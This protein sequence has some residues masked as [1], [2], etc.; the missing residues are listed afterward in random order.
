M[1]L[2][3]HSHPS[4]HQIKS[5]SCYEFDHYTK[6]SKPN[7]PLPKNG[8]CHHV[9]RPLT[10]QAGGRWTGNAFLFHICSCICFEEWLCKLLPL[11]NK[12]IEIFHIPVCVLQM[13]INFIN[14]SSNLPV[15][16]AGVDLCSSTSVHSHFDDVKWVRAKSVL[17]EQI[18]STYCTSTGECLTPSTTHRWESPWEQATASLNK[19]HT[20]NPHSGNTAL[21]IRYFDLQTCAYSCCRYSQQ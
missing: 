14:G 16:L 13:R 10:D 19:S 11:T 18:V 9:I 17:L 1:G 7:Y 2:P 6:H 4:L 8:F 12:E 20:R 3:C 15:C 5:H 21:S